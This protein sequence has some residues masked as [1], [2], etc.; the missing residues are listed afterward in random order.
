[1]NSPSLAREI[2]S[3]IMAALEHRDEIVPGHRRASRLLLGVPEIET[4]V[5]QAIDETIDRVNGAGGRHLI[6]KGGLMQKGRLNRDALFLSPRV[7][8]KHDPTDDRKLTSPR[9]A[10]ET[11][12]QGGLTY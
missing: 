2:Q 1:M 5:D 12:Q 4:G 8:G 10:G 9:S 7:R 11:R 3:Q 6:L